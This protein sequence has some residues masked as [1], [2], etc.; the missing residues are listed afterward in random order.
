MFSGPH[1]NE[2]AVIKSGRS[3]DDSEKERTAS[4]VKRETSG[5]SLNLGGDVV[6][7]LFLEGWK[8][9]GILHNGDSIQKVS[10]LTVRY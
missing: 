1:V 10:Y 8:E 2:R 6:G 4:G 9:P 7:R 3:E 5:F